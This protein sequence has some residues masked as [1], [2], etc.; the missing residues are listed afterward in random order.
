MI[1][2]VEDLHTYYGLVHMLRGVSLAVSGGEVVGLL[3]RN[4]AGKTTVIKSIMGLVPPRRGTVVFKGQDITGLPPH[5]V[6]GRGIAYVPASRGIFSALTAMENLQIVHRKGARWA[7]EDVFAMF[8]KLAE[9][10][11]RRGRFLSGGEQQMLAIGR[12]LVTNPS[13]MLLDEPSQGLAPMVVDAVL[14]M[15]RGLKRAGMGMLLV[16]QNV[17]MALDL[18]DRAIILDQGAIVFQGAAADLAT[19]DEL[20]ARYLGV[21]V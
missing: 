13:L 19:S 21:G 6:A 14:E 16:E 20:T 7:P 15:L 4:G 11:G 9:L 12:A 3:G 5:V 8:P 1:L 18:A 2:R 17:Q 10:R